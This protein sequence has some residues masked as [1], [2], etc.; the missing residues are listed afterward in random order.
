MF[1]LEEVVQRSERFKDITKVNISYCLLK[2]FA[3]AHIYYDEKE[4]EIKYDLIEPKLDERLKEII[5]R[6]FNGLLQLVDVSPKDIKSNEELIKFLED[7][8]KKLLEEYGYEISEKEYKVIM[9]YIYRDFAGLNEIEALMH[10]D[11]IEDINCNGVNI[12]I[13]VK[14]RLFGNLETNVKFTDYDKLKNFVIKLAQRCK[15]YITYANPF[16]EGSLEDGSR[17]QGTISEE[18]S[19][20]GPNFSIRK[21]RRIPFSPTELIYLGSVSSEGLAYL[22]YLIENQASILIIGGSG[23]GKTT[24]L[25]TL[26]TFIPP[27]AKIVSIEDTRE[28]RLYHENWIATVSRESVGGLHIGEVDLYKLLRE[29]F[30][31]N[32]DYV[33]VGEVRGRETYVMFQG[34]ASGH[35]TLSTFHSENLASVISRLKTPPINLPTSLIELLDVIVTLIKIE[36]GNKVVRK[37]LRIEELLGIDPRTGRVNTNSILAWDGSRDVFNYNPESRFIEKLSLMQGIK[38]EKIKKE[39]LRRKKFLDKLVKKKIFDIE[40]VQKE[41]E[42]YYN[43]L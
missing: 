41:I 25:N 13:Y 24:F 17:V 7:K 15:K 1:K 36:K 10:D 23:A 8:V 9:Y 6:V 3:K 16:L 33:I 12:N 34:I 42:N 31:E 43:R 26:A 27:R 11:Y 38:T 40:L 14:H 39:I 29:S 5:D 32:P 30:R 19:P 22:W 18:I 4:G 21:F 37:V 28:I 20:R 35:P 2:P